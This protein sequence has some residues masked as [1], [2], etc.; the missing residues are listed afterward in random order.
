MIITCTLFD[1]QVL[2]HAKST[3]IR[4]IC[5][6]IHC[7]VMCIIIILYISIY[8]YIIMLFS[9]ITTL[10]ESSLTYMCVCMSMPAHVYVCV[11][12]VLAN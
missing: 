12:C 4:I 7:H 5:T 2:W 8:M 6:Y 1:I 3:L 11:V 10:G 9:I